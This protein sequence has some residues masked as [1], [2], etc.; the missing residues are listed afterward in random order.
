MVDQFILADITL[1]EKMQYRKTSRSYRFCL[2]KLD[3]MHY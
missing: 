1:T 3:S 2:L